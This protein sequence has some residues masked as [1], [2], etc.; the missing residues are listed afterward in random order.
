[1]GCELK[2]GISILQLAMVFLLALGALSSAQADITTTCQWPPV[3]GVDVGDRC[4]DFSDWPAD[5]EWEAID[6]RTEPDSDGPGTGDGDMELVGSSSCPGLYF[7]AKND[8][9]FWRVRVLEE[10]SDTGSTFF[11]YNNGD[12]D[13]PMYAFTWDSQS[14]SQ[15]LNH[16]LEAQVIDPSALPI[17]YWTDVQ[18]DDLDGTNSSKCWQDI[19]GPAENTGCGFDGSLH[20]GYVRTAVGE[21]PASSGCDSTDGFID[22]AVAC[23]YFDR[24]NDPNEIIP[25]FCDELGQFH[26]LVGT[27]LGVNDH[28]ELQN[29]SKSDVSGGIAALGSASDL[30]ASTNWDNEPTALGLDYFR[31]RRFQQAPVLL[32]WATSEGHNMIGFNIYRATTSEGP[33]LPVNGTMIPATPGDSGPKEYSFEDHSATVGLHFYQLETF[34]NMGL[35]ETTE[36]NIL[37][38]RVL[39]VCGTTGNVAG[40][41]V[42]IMLVGASILLYQ[43]RRRSRPRNETGS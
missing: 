23:S 28:G 17:T 31:A 9:L 24:V 6:S 37:K 10:F 11:Y 8:Y 3:D 41:G 35:A 26:T 40:S 42:V 27:L 15:P 16:G 38:V 18:M 30:V 7:K 19:D 34:D 20:E 32:E 36:E 22:I 1:M 5:S 29:S 12:E 13:Y 21:F 14:T 2:S 43:A 25:D 33:W 4:I 39:P